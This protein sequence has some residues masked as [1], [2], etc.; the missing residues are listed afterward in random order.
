MTK[1]QKSLLNAIT[2]LL[3]MAVT[4]VV[5]LV[6]GKTILMQYGSAYN[7]VN[8]TISQIISTIM[9]LEGGFTLASNIALFEPLAKKDYGVA[10]G[11]LAAT[12]KRFLTVGG[13]AFLIGIIIALV[14][15]L[16]VSSEI[17]YFDFFLLM[18]TVLIPSCFNLGVNMKHRV[19]LLT[20]QK[21]YIISISSTITYLIGNIAAIIAMNFGVSL[22]V[23]RMIIMA[24][25]LLNYGLVGAYCRYKY[26]FVNY[27]VKPM[28]K[29]IKG[30]KSVI[31]L[32]L[33]TLAY[34]TLPIIAISVI[35]EKG[36]LLASVYAV[37]K[38]IIA[39]IRNC[40]SSITNAP[41]LGFGALLA[42]GR[43]EEAKKLFVHYEL[44]TC[45]GLGVV[46]GATCLLILPFVDVYTMGV[47]DANYHDVKLAV[48]MLLTTFLE[49]LHIP[50]GQM[51]QMAGKFEA[52]KA[53]QLWACILLL[54]TLIG[55]GALF[56]LYGIVAS[57][58]IAAAFLALAEIIYTRRKIFKLGI[59]SFV[60]NAAPCTIVCL[61]TTII[62]L[63]GLIEVKN[64]LE[65][66]IYGVISVLFLGSVTVLL[67]LFVDKQ[68]MIMLL[69]LVK[70]LFIRHK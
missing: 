60:K 35:P 20:E 56:G 57:T 68:Q 26:P 48:I 8:A 23:A 58:L 44:I 67:Y 29:K 34:T 41:R 6:L 32:K 40:L 65:F 31:A 25:L 10:N 5:G 55:G 64:Y 51:I 70:G 22:L 18:L 66:A 14:Y 7:G 21:E 11:I 69:R 37:Y 27:S 28:F 13:I 1:S 15:P 9:V 38:S 53:I 36:T 24:S 62:G 43:E 47:N 61:T 4:S 50:S 39:M 19:L 2:A 42:E 63:S 52:S 45:I 59:K 16:L 49:I 33:T 12:K 54:I 3:N 17:P 30:T 46:L